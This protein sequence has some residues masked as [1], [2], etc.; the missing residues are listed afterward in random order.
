MTIQEEVLRLAEVVP[1]EPGTLLPPGAT[2]VEIDLIVTLH[3]VRIPPEV[4]DWLRFTNGPKIG[5]GGING[6]EDFCRV[7]RYRTTFKERL[8]LPLGTDGCGCDYVLALESEDKPLRPV[9]F[10]DPYSSGLDTPTYAVASGF[11]PF[12]RF[13]FRHELGERGWPFDAAF[14]LASDPDLARVK[15]AP[16]PWVAD[17]ATRD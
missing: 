6:L 15:G 14:V 1:R 2:D 13:M 9:Y 17:E 8:W 3:G 5:F 10:V 7:Y 11:W 4:R 16:L 12:L